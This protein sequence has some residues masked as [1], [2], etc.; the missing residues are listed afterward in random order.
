MQDKVGSMLEDFER[1]M[2]KRMEE[3]EMKFR[4]FKI[5][6]EFEKKKEELR[7]EETSLL[8]QQIGNLRK[9]VRNAMQENERL[10]KVLEDIFARSADEI[11]SH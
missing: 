1:K 10:A 9:D 2:S 3:D 8:K 4:M 11:S 5:E 7:R 6:R